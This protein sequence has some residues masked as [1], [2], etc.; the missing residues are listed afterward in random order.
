[1]PGFPVVAL[2]VSPHVADFLPLT[3]AVSTSWPW[4][5]LRGSPRRR[6]RGRTRGRAPPA[7]SGRWACWRQ[8]A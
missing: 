1:V 5:G 3:E 2:P 8:L 6:R 7:C 4:P